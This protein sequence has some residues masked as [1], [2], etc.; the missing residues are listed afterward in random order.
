MKNRRSI[1]LILHNIRSAENVGAL[2]RTADFAGVSKIILVGTT[3]TPVDRFGRK[4]IDIHK[5]ALGA[6]SF[7]S[8]EY[9]RLIIPLLNSMKLERFQTISI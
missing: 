8:W 2:F 7:V 5:S 6:E 4:R 1:Y 3:P 9:K